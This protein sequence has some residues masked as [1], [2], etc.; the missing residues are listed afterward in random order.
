MPRFEN[1]GFNP[2]SNNDRDRTVP[3]EENYYG[4]VPID[5]DF[6]NRTSADNNIV[7]DN[8]RTQRS[9]QEIH[10]K[11][12]SFEDFD[13][14]RNR[15]VRDNGTGS[16]PRKHRSKGSSKST[17]ILAVLLVLVLVLIGSVMPVLARINYDDAKENEYISSSELAGS[18][19]VKNVLLLGVDARSGEDSET[20]RSDAMMLISVDSKHNCIKMTSFLRDSWVYI[21]SLGYEQRLNAACSDGGYQNVVDTIEYNFGVDIDGYVVA[22]F[23]M[24]KVLVDS[25]GGIKVDVSKS[26]AKEINKHPKRYGNVKIEA[27]ENTLTGEQALAYCRIRK[28]D[29]DF[30]RTKRQRTVIKAILGKV[31]SNPI[32]LYGMAYKS[33]P[34]IE[35]SLSKGELMSF[36]SKAMLCAGSAYQEKVPFDN[37]WNYA[38]IRGNSVISINTEKNKDMLI[39]FIYNQSKADLEKAEEAE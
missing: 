32:R 39:D 6:N 30:E 19:S 24:F 26:E 4:Q 16:A 35:T 20:S 38:T 9:S 18:S 2:N 36:A 25:I 7:K 5:L 21:P 14:G 3:P 37:T 13:T 28:I 23:E 27:G 10:F 12:E 31:K 1:D 22:D 8:Q 15:P 11:S 33:A 34:Y 17:K 29:T